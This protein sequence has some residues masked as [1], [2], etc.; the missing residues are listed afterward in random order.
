MDL[1][2]NRKRKDKRGMKHSSPAPLRAT[3]GPFDGREEPGCDRIFVVVDGTESAASSVELGKQLA[4]RYVVPW[5]AIFAETPKAR[6]ELSLT[7]AGEALTLAA[8]LGAMV[9]R[10]PGATEADAICEHIQASAAPHVVLTTT[11]R[12][13]AERLQSPSLMAELTRR[14]SSIVFHAVAAARPAGRAIGLSERAA[15]R[16]YVLAAIGSLATLALVLI[17]KLVTGTSYLSV[18]FLFPV[19]AAAASLGLGPALVAAVISSTGFNV[20]ILNPARSFNPWAVQTWLMFT[21]LAAVAA[22]TSWLTSTLRGRLAL[23]DR[24]ARESAALAAFAQTLTR[25]A[26]WGSTADAVCREVADILNVQTLVVREIGGELHVVSSLPEGVQLDPLDKAALDWAWQTG[27]PT[28]SGTLI[29]SEAS[30]QFQPLMTS[31]GVL[32]V[33]GLARDDGRNPIPP[34]RE[35]LLGTI[36]A[37][38]ALAH[39]RLRLE[40]AQRE[41]SCRLQTRDGSA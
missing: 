35:I 11:P 24:S 3:G 25:V 15:A 26:D 19:I 22:Y 18:L 40:D 9:F 4:D 12:T 14:N 13:L 32:A 7:R 41:I 34:E 28:G 38:A 23:S 27:K 20:L 8:G 30:W 16:S 39:E 31:L 21:V 29:V 10:L 36:V 37:Q 5:E 2:R 17:L 1:A 33:L 6:D